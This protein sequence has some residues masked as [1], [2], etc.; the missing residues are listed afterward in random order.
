MM[1]QKPQTVIFDIDGTLANNTHRQHLVAEGRMSWEKFFQQMGDDTPIGPIIDLCETLSASKRYEV[2]L[3]TGRPE[4]FR[5]L[6][7]QWLAWNGVPDL[8]LE[9]RKDG[10][11]RPDREVKQDMLNAQLEQ[12]TKIAF[13]VDDRQ[14]V[15]DMWRENGIICLQCAPHDF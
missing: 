3:F 4:R 6:T 13:V 11:T 14:S 1:S 9:M 5:R 15:V 2:L 12:G 8:P 10:D 7:E